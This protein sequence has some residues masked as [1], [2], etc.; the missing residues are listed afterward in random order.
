MFFANENGNPEFVGSIGSRTA[1]ANNDQITES[2]SSAVYEAMTNAMNNANQNGSQKN[3]FNIYI[4]RKQMTYQVEEE[5]RSRG[6][7]IFS[8]GVADV[9]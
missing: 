9:R 7:T 5:Q 3:D 4:G 1:V 8:G 2:I 6:K